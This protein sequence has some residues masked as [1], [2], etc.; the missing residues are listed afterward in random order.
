MLIKEQMNVLTAGEDKEQV[1]L[2]REISLYG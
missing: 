2:Y 1:L